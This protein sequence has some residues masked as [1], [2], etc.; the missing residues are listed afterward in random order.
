MK[1]CTHCGKEMSE[2]ASFCPHCGKEQ[3]RDSKHKM[4]GFLKKW[5]VAALILGVFVFV[6]AAVSIGQ[7]IMRNRNESHSSDKKVSKETISNQKE[8]GEVEKQADVSPKSQKEAL[9]RLVAEQQ[10]LGARVSEDLTSGEYWWDAD[11][12]LIGIHWEDSSL[13]GDIS[14]SDFPQLEVLDCEGNNLQSM[15]ITK[16][17]LLK[18]LNCRHGK[19]QSLDISNNT[20]LTKLDCFGNEITKLNTSN[21]TAL[22]ELNCGDN[23]LQ[24]IDITKNTAL[25][26]LSCEYNSLTYL[27]L[28]NNTALRELNCM[29]NE[30]EYLD[31]TNNPDLTDLDCGSNKLEGFDLHNNIDLESLVCSNNNLVYLDLTDNTQLVLLWC[32]DNSELSSVDLCESIESVQSDSQTIFN[33]FDY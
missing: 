14:F 19:L 29:S 28:A 30:L 3:T 33:Y 11:E 18:E 1:Y 16:N 22:E 20:A 26:I 6:I 21:N 31:V 25:E 10:A 17:K 5:K 2:I 9:K 24:Y 27:N 8:E 32:K 15:D 23:K 4:G 12:N 13:M 7:A